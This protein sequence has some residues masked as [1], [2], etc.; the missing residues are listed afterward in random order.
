MHTHSNNPTIIYLHIHILW[1][2]HKVIL[3]FYHVISYQKFGRMVIA[4]EMKLKQF[5][6]VAG[7]SKFQ[8]RTYCKR[9]K[10][11]NESTQNNLSLANSHEDNLPLRK[12][13]FIRKFEIDQGGSCS[14]KNYRGRGRVCVS[15]TFMYSQWFPLVSDYRDGFQS[16][17][18]C[19]TLF[20]P[21]PHHLKVRA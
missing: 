12:L 19:S 18:P 11:Q 7:R 1:K 16:F 6:G 15:Y 14:G 8:L 20:L 21:P 10:C 2:G 4:H 9:K 3:P 13:L 5:S 17:V